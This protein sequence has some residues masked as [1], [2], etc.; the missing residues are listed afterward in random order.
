MCPA[1][2]AQLTLEFSDYFMI[3]PTIAF[4]GNTQ[5]A[6]NAL[7]EVGKPVKDDFEYSSGTNTEWLTADQLK[8]MIKQ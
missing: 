5:F 1:D 6:R 7:G 8:D 4:S 2:G 3:Q